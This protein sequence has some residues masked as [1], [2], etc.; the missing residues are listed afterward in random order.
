MT[1]T[2]TSGT[3]I[4]ET[5]PVTVDAAAPASVTVANSGV[6]ARVGTGVGTLPTY[7]VRDAFSNL[8]P[9]LSVSYSSL[10]SGAFSGQLTTNASGVA[11]LTSWTMAGTAA[12]DA[13]GRMAN[14]VTLTAGSASGTAI[15]Y[16]I[17]NLSGDVQPIYN[18]RCTGCHVGGG[19]APNLTTGNSR[20][21]TVGV[22]ASCDA[23]R[24]RVNAGNAAASVLYLRVSS[25][26]E[27]SGAMPPSASVTVPTS[28]QKVIRA[29]INNGA[30]SN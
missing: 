25:T 1:A 27:C 15:D 21:S 16:G 6:S 10:N 22:V 28:E 5:T 20:T 17:Y 19:T 11:A 18:L 9:N 30:Q 29:W 14:S 3:T 26:T 8:V 13:F 4:I 2:I 24:F 7:T 12:D 23:A